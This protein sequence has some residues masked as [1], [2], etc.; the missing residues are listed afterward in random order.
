MY[1]MSDIHL[2]KKTNIG[3]QGGLHYGYIG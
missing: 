1:Y 3:T 2:G